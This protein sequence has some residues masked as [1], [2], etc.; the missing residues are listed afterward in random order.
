[1]GSALANPSSI[2][3]QKLSFS[4]TR[5]HI[6]ADRIPFFTTKI[7]VFLLSSPRVP[8]LTR[9]PASIMLINNEFC[10]P[11]FWMQL[12]GL[13][14]LLYHRELACAAALTHER[15]PTQPQVATCGF[16]VETPAAT[17]EKT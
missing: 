9:T 10:Q 16:F 12:R 4:R 17:Q 11:L 7:E 13:V 15:I 14:V 2:L 8:S 3:I 1:M 5:S 6:K